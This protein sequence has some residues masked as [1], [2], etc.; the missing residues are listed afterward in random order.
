MGATFLHRK[1][2]KKGKHGEKTHHVVVQGPGKKAA[3]DQHR[4]AMDPVLLPTGELA[5]HVNV[6]LSDNLTIKDRH[7]IEKLEAMI[8]YEEAHDRPVEAQKIRE[9]IEVINSKADVKHKQEHDAPITVIHSGGH[10]HKKE[11]HE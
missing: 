6:T 2:Q 11:H 5:S 3:N 4:K 10:K 7:V 9:R 1:E 8:E